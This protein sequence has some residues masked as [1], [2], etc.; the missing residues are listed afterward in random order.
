ML[1]IEPATGDAPEPSDVHVLGGDV[2]DAG[3]TL[4][5]AHGAALGTGFADAVGT[6]IL[7]T[8]TSADPDDYANGIWYLDPS[9]GPGASLAL[10][11][12]P[13]GWQYEGWV[14]GADGPI[15]TGTFTDPNAADADGAGAT[16]GTDNAGPPFPGQDFVTPPTAL[17][18][19]TAVISVEPSPDDSPAPFALKPLVGAITDAGAGTSQ[20]LGLNIDALP[21]GTVTFE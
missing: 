19:Y 3:A 16:A 8:P 5:I 12:L 1:T 11:T 14:V 20:P 17:A 13:A 18:G 4:T 9:A 10:P 6:F 21:Q 15:S 7:E 2:T